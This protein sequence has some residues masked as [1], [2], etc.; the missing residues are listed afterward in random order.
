MEGSITIP[1]ELLYWMVSIVSLACTIVC[2]VGILGF[3]AIVK[4]CNDKSHKKEEKAD[5]G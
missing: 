2:C 1:V 5:G 4:I 3:V